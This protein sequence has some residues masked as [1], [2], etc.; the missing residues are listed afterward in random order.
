MRVV[1]VCCDLW[2]VCFGLC[3]LVIFGFGFGVFG[4]FDYLV[5]GGN[6]L[7]LVC[8]VCRVWCFGC[9]VSCGACCCWVFSV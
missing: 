2:V 8:E 5:G 9:H 1:F 3:G 4:F 6:F 7:S